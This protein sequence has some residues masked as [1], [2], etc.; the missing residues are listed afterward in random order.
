M[1]KLVVID[2]KKVYE[3]LSISGC[4]GCYRYSFCHAGLKNRPRCMANERTDN[5][6]VRYT[7]TKC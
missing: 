2:G 4:C 1:N 6:S 5:K 3:Q 7:L